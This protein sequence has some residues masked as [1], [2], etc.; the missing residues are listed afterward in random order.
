[1]KERKSRE[2]T[3]INNN[4]KGDRE[5]D[6]KHGLSGGRSARETAT[7]RD[8]ILGGH[9]MILKENYYAFPSFLTYEC[10]YNV[11]YLC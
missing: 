6:C 9:Y 8:D 1:M 2:R 11:G 4:G 7:P 5:R 10:C 3:R